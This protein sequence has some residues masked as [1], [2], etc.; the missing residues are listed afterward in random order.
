[1]H[2]CCFHARR[3]TIVPIIPICLE[4]QQQKTFYKLIIINCTTYRPYESSVS[5]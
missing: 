2:S 4:V 3:Q 5:V 1:M